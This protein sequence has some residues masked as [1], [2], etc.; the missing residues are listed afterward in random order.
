[1]TKSYHSVIATHQ[2]RIR[3]FLH[4]YII[5]YAKENNNINLVTKLNNSPSI[6]RFQNGSIIKFEVNSKQVKI[7]LLYNGEIDEE[8]P[9][10]IYYVKPGTKD[11]KATEGKY[12][13]QEFPEIILQN[14]DIN[15]KKNVN[16]VYYLIRHGQAEHNLLT[17]IKKMS[18]SKNTS[19]TKIGEKQ[20]ETT[21]KELFKII[22]Q[23]PIDFIFASDLSRTHQTIGLIISEINKNILN[24]KIIIL[25]CSH[26][27]SYTKKNNCD[28]DV[29]YLN[30]PNENISTC[31]LDKNL[32]NKC[33]DVYNIPIDWTFYLSYY[34]GTR[35]ISKNNKKCRD[36]NMVELSIDYIN[37]IISN[38]INNLVSSVLTNVNVNSNTK[39]D[40]ISNLI[41]SVLHILKNNTMNNNIVNQNIDNISNAN[42]DTD[43]DINSYQKKD[44]IS[45][46]IKSVLHTLDKNNNDKT[47]RNLNYDNYETYKVLKS[48]EI[49]PLKISSI[50][51][52]VINDSNTNNNKF[53]NTQLSELL[54]NS[55][56]NISQMYSNTKNKLSHM[57][58]YF[59]SDNIDDEPYQWK[60]CKEYKNFETP[61]QIINIKDKCQNIINNKIDKNDW[62]IISILNEREC[63]I[64]NKK[65]KENELIDLES[66]MKLTNAV[67]DTVVESI[68]LYKKLNDKN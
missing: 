22:G 43:M 9:T 2:A 40:D 41:K 45:N 61:K 14:Y 51:L 19:L 30:T 37:N 47:E 39:N 20:A 42:T 65:T 7:N 11:L 3:C 27:L 23:Q 57:F 59:N 44:N 8:K 64:Y 18:S 34:K 58:D 38:E 36:I 17:G 31:E 10:Y 24:N 28:Y 32:I 4:N 13:I 29:S 26:E 67:P 6:H 54:S 5:Q 50:V 56:D 62:N 35:K 1:M 53:S 25:P 52:N 46:I 16:Y 60:T 68:K 15:C 12:Q 55:K 33:K 66:N 48:N 49:D 63:M 21:G